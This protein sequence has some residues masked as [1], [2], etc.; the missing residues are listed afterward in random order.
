M[1]MVGIRNR[2][3]LGFLGGLQPWWDRSEITGSPSQAG[4]GLVAEPVVG[5]IA[6][7]GGGMLAEPAVG[8][9]QPVVVAQVV[10]AWGGRGS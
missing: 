10:H 1:S 8:L 7:P 9:A 2:I 6:E 4:V 5:M 3:H